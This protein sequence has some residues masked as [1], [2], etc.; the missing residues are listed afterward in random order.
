M[1]TMLYYIIMTLLFPFW[2]FDA[3]SSCMLT[4]RDQSHGITR[5]LVHVAF[6]FSSWP[7]L[8]WELWCG[9]ATPLGVVRRVHQE[10]L[11]GRGKAII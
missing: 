6:M 11:L 4:V 8:L 5:P 10:Y 7:V 1:R 9:D 2:V 3:L